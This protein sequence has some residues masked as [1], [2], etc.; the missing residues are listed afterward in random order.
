MGGSIL[1]EG[2][3][4]YLKILSIG[5]PSEYFYN[6]LIHNTV[7]LEK[8]EIECN[9]ICKGN[10]FFN[11][12]LCKILLRYLENATKRSQIDYSA[13]DD[14]ILFN[15]WIYGELETKYRYNYNNKL[16]PA[17]GELHRAWNDLLEDISKKSYHDK[18]IPDFDIPKQYDWKKRKQLYD[19]CVN[20]E[21]LKKQSEFYK[22]NCRHIYS[23]VKSSAPLYKHF[24][25][26]CVSNDENKC[27]K[28]YNKCKEYDPDIVL[29]TLSCYNDLHKEEPTATE[30]VSSVGPHPELRADGT[31]SADGSQ[32]QGDNTPPLT[33]AGDVLLGVVATT[34]TSGALYKFT[35]IG[36]M[37]RNGFGWNNNMRNLNG[38][39]NRLFD[40]ASESFN[41][42]SGGAEEHYIGYH[43]A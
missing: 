43:P 14:C 1:W 17:L 40:Y 36:R 16:I 31:Y 38:A 24:K 15:Y 37:L 23:Y 4:R 34:M 11:N 18:C 7:G 30:K 28:F 5:L 21:S 13:Y 26:S 25:T 12:R 35:P 19:Y 22:N 33:K 27:P 32:L 9:S 39:D 6:T 2:L 10:K 42:Y 29:P 20:Y 3:D 8:Y 41:P